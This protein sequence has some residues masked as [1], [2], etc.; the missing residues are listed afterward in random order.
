MM[1][2]KRTCPECGK[3]MLDHWKSCRWCDAENYLSLFEDQDE[4]HDNFENIC[5]KTFKPTEDK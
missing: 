1:A 2:E 4:A 3:F 5:R